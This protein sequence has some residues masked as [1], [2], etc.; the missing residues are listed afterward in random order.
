MTGSELRKLLREGE[1]ENLEFKESFDREAVETAGAFANARGGII[2]VGVSGKRQ[3]TGVELGK[4]TVN[5]WA[6]QISSATDP[7]VIPDIEV[8]KTGRTTVAAVRIKESSIKPVSIRGRC[9]R[10]VGSSNRMMTTREI[11]EFHE[12]STGATWDLT[13]ASRRYAGRD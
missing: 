7:R 2:L 11:T 12:L 13:P 3:P 4:G 5:D 6:N 1:S 8:L 10:R 9:Y